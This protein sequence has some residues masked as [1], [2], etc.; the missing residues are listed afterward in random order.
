[1]ER[2]MIERVVNG[3]THL[4]ALTEHE[5]EKVFDAVQ[6]HWDRV[7]VIMWFES[8]YTDADIDDFDDDAIDEIAYRKRD[9][10][11]GDC[12]NW[13]DAVENAVLEYEANKPG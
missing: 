11:D 3:E 9:I 10:Q 13:T 2:F 5:M 12:M 4:F 6:H 1:M 7:D 8:E